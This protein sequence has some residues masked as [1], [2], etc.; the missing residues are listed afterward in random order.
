MV[1]A[2]IRKQRK[3]TRAQFLYLKERMQVFSTGAINIG[4][5]SIGVNRNVRPCGIPSSLG[6]KNLMRRT[7]P[8]SQYQAVAYEWEYV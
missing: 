6:M 2:S 5:A 4:D 1:Q 8:V 7:T 3:E